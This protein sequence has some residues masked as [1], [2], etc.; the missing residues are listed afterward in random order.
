MKYTISVFSLILTW[1]TI[2]G[3]YAEDLRL[4]EQPTGGMQYRI[5]A[6][7]DVAGTLTIPSEKEKQPPKSLTVKGESSIDYDERILSVG[8]NGQVE[9]T[10]RIY[11]RI[12]FQR[13]IGE[14]DQQ[15]TIRPAV[16]RM[17]LLRHDTL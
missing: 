7:V 15:S 8:T 12:D 13:K 6:R 1:G 2:S 16:R 3:L 17:V 5:N 9:K 4:R 14:Q 10:I 11:Q